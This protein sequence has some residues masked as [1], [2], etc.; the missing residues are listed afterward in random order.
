MPSMVSAHSAHAATPGHRC[1]RASGV[2]GVTAMV[3]GAG[4]PSG[5]WASSRASSLTRQC[6]RRPSRERYG[7]RV[8]PGCL[9]A[10]PGL[11]QHLHPKGAKRPLRLWMWPDGA[12]GAEALDPLRWHAPGGQGLGGVIASGGRGRAGAG[13]AAEA[14]GGGGVVWGRGGGRGGGGGGGGG[15]GAAPPQKGGGGG[16]WG[17]GG[18]AL[19]E[20]QDRG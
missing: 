4:A 2:A 10:A 13:G 17:G 7:R 16:W 15:G 19:E 11:I 1:G 3:L 6:V 12:G 14:G 20:G 9:A 8:S 5:L 18:G